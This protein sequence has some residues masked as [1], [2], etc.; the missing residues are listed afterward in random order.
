MESQPE[1]AAAGS[2]LRRRGRSPAEPASAE[3]PSCLLKP[4]E[5]AGRNAVSDQFPTRDPRGRYVT[6]AY[7]AWVPAGA[8]ARAGDDAA[9]VRWAPLDRLPGDLAF[10]HHQILADALALTTA[11]PHH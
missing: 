8:A 4:N 5:T 10:D 6:V 9:A 7:L 11:T 1:L 3:H 2:R